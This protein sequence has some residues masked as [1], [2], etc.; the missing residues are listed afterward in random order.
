MLEVSCKLTETSSKSSNGFTIGDLSRKEMKEVSAFCASPKHLKR[1]LVVFYWQPLPGRFLLLLLMAILLMPAQV[2]VVSASGSNVDSEDEETTEGTQARQLPKFHNVRY[3]E[4]WSVLA[5]QPTEGLNRIKYIQLSDTGSIFFGV[6][7]QL[8]LRSESWWNFGFG[9]KG[10]R[11]DTF[12]LARLRLH[13]DLHIG[14][15]L[16][17]FIEG[18]SSLSTV[19]DLPAGRRNLDVDTADFQNVLLDLRSSLDSAQLTARL[20]RQELQFGN[21]RLV[22]P[23]DWSNTRRSWDGAR[24]FYE[25]NGWRFDGFWSRYVQVKKYDLN[26]SPCSGIQF[27]GVYTTKQGSRG[28]PGIDIYWLGY[29]RRNAEFGGREAREKRQT[30]GGRV[31]GQMASTSGYYDLESA[32][33]FGD[34]GDDSISSLMF[35]GLIGHNWMGSRF[36]P[37]VYGAFDY[38]SGDDD[39]ADGKLGTFNQLFPLGHAYLGYADVVGRQNIIDGSLGFSASPVPRWTA[40]FDLHN[41]WRA[42]LGDALYNPGGSVVRA[43]LSGADRRIGSEIDMTI[44][45]AID[46]HWIVSAGYSH[47]FAGPFIRQ[48]GSGDNISFLYFMVQTT[49]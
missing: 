44:A 36:S 48:T 34:Y 3:E 28:Q 14:P 32:Y 20:G 46:R 10:N 17:F 5:S 23:L 39:P 24:G 2:L 21:Q 15:H 13:G 9:G 33:Q 38:A 42:S 30:I 29:D 11:D 22:S 27:Y 47:F 1:S 16:R 4:D 40:Q 8:R 41:F 19:R 37:R 49:F 7:G 6:G 18:K 45:Y 25:N 12:G 31:G 43:P 26:C 35:T